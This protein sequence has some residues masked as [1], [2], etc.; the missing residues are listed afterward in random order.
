M[1]LIAFDADV[2][3]YTA[4]PQHALGERIATLLQDAN[5]DGRRVGSTLLLPELLIK[6]TRQNN[7]DERRSLLASLSYLKLLAAG[8]TVAHL[9]VRL[10]AAYGLRMPDATHLA[11]AVHAGADIFI[12]N[13]RKDFDREKILELTVVYPDLL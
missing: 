10:G 3:V 8:E 2:L 12:T 9:A 11:T 4:I 1:P 6:P 5:L 13:N 7:D